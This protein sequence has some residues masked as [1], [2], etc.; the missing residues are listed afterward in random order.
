MKELKSYCK[1][2]YPGDSSL[3]C[4]DHVRY[5]R[6]RNIFFNFENLNAKTSN[7]R[8]RENIFS[9]GQVGGKCKFNADAFKKQGDHKSPLQSWY[10]E[11][12]H[13]KAFEEIPDTKCDMLINGPSIVIKLDAGINMY[14]HFCDFINLYVS[15]HSNNSFFQNTQIGK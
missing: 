10:A 6:G 15:Q 11:L 7:D 9:P 12:E 13:F 3:E 8:Y 1:P 14:H 2:E 4:V 5:C